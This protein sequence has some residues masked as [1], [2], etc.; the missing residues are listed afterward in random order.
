VL[1]GGR[2]L[3]FELSSTHQLYVLQPIALRGREH[4]G[5]HVILHTARGEKVDQRLRGLLSFAAEMALE[6]LPARAPGVAAAVTRSPSQRITVAAQRQ[7]TAK[8]RRDS[9]PGRA[10]E[11][12]NH[13]SCRRAASVGE[14]SA[15]R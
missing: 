15:C 4:P 11:S 12:A 9:G 5:D 14:W 7:P 10:S 8:L 1:G 2:P 3:V 13:S 6:L